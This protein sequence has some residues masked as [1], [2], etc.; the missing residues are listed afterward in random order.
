MVLNT[1]TNNK[2]AKP[3]AKMSVFSLDEIELSF[4]SIFIETRVL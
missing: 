3:K 2:Q 1:G 4:F